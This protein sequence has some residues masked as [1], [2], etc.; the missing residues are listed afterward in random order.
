MNTENKPNLN[1]SLV[2]LSEECGEVVQECC[3]IL[4]F[5][6]TEDNRE[7][8]EKE[9]GDVM[10]LFEYLSDRGYID[11]AE[12]ALRVPIKQEKLTRYSSLYE[13]NNS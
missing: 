8:L 5:G 4:R 2:I 9:I 13:T 11:W 3:K 10:C 6:M 1:E 12:V 7:R